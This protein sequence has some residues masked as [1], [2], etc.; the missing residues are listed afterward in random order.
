MFRKKWILL[1]ALTAALLLSGCAMST[2]ED[3][4]APP[5]RSEAYSRLQSAIDQAMTGMEFAAPVSGE[6]QQ[7]VQ[8][9]DVNGDGQ[10]EYILFARAN[11]DMPLQ[12]LVFCQEEDGQCSLIQVIQSAGLAFEQVEFVDVDG[13]PGSEIVVGRQVSD[14]LL[15]TLSVYSFSSGEASLLMSAAY[16]RYLS[17]DLDADGCSELLLLRTGETDADRGYAVLYSYRDGQMQRSRE[18]GLSDRGNDVKRVMTGRLHGGETAVFVA[19]ALEEGAI[20]TD[21]FALREG[22]LTNIARY[23][24]SDSSVKTLRNHYVYGDDLDGDGILELPFLINMKAAQGQQSGEQQLI[25]WYSL[26]IDGREINKLY[27]YHNYLGGWYLELDS[28]WAPRVSVVQEGGSYLFYLW[29]ETYMSARVLFTI[30]SFTGS[31]RETQATEEGRFRLHTT[32]TTVFAAK[33]EQTALDLGITEEDLTNSFRQI[34][35]DWNTGET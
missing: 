20:V 16:H 31:S 35:Q 9:A 12:I 6:N 33:L 5:R 4:Y 14:Q 22:E 24:D 23:G 11:S 26:D 19:S 17:C 8:M 32:E 13:Q 28:G 30:Y 27:T 7:T 2:V 18:A 10:E 1:L 3:M 25:R 34:R 15:K 29:D 21:V